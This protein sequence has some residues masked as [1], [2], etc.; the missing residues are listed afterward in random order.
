MELDKLRADLLQLPDNREL[1]LNYIK[2]WL[3]EHG[4]SDNPEAA[5]HLLDE[6]VKV[7]ADL[8]QIVVTNRTLRDKTGDTIAAVNRANNPP[9]LFERAGHPVRIATDES[10]TPYIDTMTESA[11]RGH[12]E[13]VANYV[14]VG[15]KGETAP[16]PAPP[17]EV[18]RDYMTFLNKGL[19]PLL[20]I[21]EAP[22][23]RPD[24]SVVSQ[25]GYDKATM[26]YYAPATEL[27]LPAIPDNPTMNDA[28][29]AIEL[30]LEIICDFPFDS[31][32]SEANAI[33]A[34][35]TP[36]YRPMI[37]GPV[38]MCLFDKPSPGTGSTL[39][40]SIIA[41]I[42]TGRDGAVMTA[43]STDEE[44]EKRL[45]SA[46]RRGRSVII[47]D[48]VEGTLWSPSLA[49]V[50]TATTI[51][52][53][54]LGQSEDIL[55]PN[56]V[57]YICT[58]NNVRLDGDL[59][60][61]CYLSRMD[62]RDI[63]PW[64]RPQSQFRHPDLTGWT[65]HNRGSILAAILILA[66]VWIQAGKP[67]AAEPVV[68][69]GFEDWTTVVGGILGYVG[70]NG[71]LTNLESMYEKS[72]VGTA[73]WDSFLSAWHEL[74]GDERITVAELIRAIKQPNEI[75]DLSATLP[76]AIDR[77]D[78]KI[79]RSLGNQLSR[80]ADQRYPCGLMV[81][82]VGEKR[83]AKTWQVVS[84]RTANSPDL[85]LQG[86]L[87]EL[88]ATPRVRASNTDDIGVA[89]DSPNSLS[90]TK[91]GELAHPAAA[92][93]PPPL[94]DNPCYNC[95]SIEWYYSKEGQPVCGVC[96]PEPND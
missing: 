88:R 50:L 23:L 59:P 96:H 56:R 49:M 65:R 3:T 71:F 15:E 55:L 95:K 2:G 82:K 4:N 90:G 80:R 38:P 78:K 29:K 36:V 75:L 9:R 19:P 7:D 70:I 64:K 32:A 89:T 40:S 46:L 92:S 43:P 54:I 1:R 94:P 57:T 63:R 41:Y 18:T 20:S 11:I 83:H 44:F 6:T 85:A 33:A 87:S 30:L 10:N 26:L 52:S 53:R 76:D 81:K 61:R 77:D 45:A 66:R 12:I 16:L 35:V 24:G 84:Y 31:Q 68:L 39:L 17:L 74:F 37:R 91:G 69:G 86:E 51:Q 48:N 72:D 73:Q 27:L 13:R 58:G 42:A 93:D 5:F 14:R 62:A 60:R 8:P 28:G 34:M 79:N 21:A 25:P 22:F 47:I 67:P